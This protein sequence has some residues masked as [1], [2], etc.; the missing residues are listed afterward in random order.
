MLLEGKSTGVC[1]V[2]QGP[3]AWVSSGN[4]FVLLQTEKES[5][6]TSTGK[7]MLA[8]FLDH[9]GPLLID[10]LPKVITVS[11]DLYGGTLKCNKCPSMLSHSLLWQCQT[12][13]CK[14]FLL[15]AATFSVGS[16]S[17]ST[18]QS[19]LASEGYHVFEPIKKGTQKPPLFH[20]RRYTGINHTVSSST[21]TSLLQMWHRRPCETV[22]CLFKQSWGICWITWSSCCVVC[23]VHL[24]IKE[25]L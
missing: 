7:V 12:P 18:L 25:L 11:T 19:T 16:F 5:C 9:R 15:E 23:T 1:I 6:H 14:N 17:A 2:I 13:I 10:W 24:F 20:S 3:N 8:L 4:F 22:G 21:A